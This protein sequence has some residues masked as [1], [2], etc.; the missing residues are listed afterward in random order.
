[1]RRS[2]F[3]FLA[4]LMMLAL[5]ASAVSAGSPHFIKSATSASASGNGLP[6]DTGDVVTV[7][8]KEAGLQSGTTET[9]QI[10]LSRTATYQCVNG[11]GNV[12]SDPKKTTTSSA[13]TASGQFTAGTSGNIEG[14]LSLTLAPPP[15][16][17]SFNCPGGQHA[18]LLA[19]SVVYGTSVTLSDLTSSVSTTLSL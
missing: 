15:A 2:I 8:F 1:M 6:L 11:G 9:V 10:S 14:S 3:A 12:P 13:A 16:P 17:A 4:A 19:G 18:E 5:A 7:V